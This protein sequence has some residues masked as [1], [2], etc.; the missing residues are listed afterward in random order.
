[1]VLKQYTQSDQRF[2]LVQAGKYQQ[3]NDEEVGLLSLGEQLGLLIPAWLP[4]T[5][6][7]YLLH[8]FQ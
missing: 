1:V 6:V 3:V 8:G 7:S 2:E 4:P 5:P